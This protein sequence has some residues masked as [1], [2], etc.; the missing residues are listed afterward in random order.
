MGYLETGIMHDQELNRFTFNVNIDHKISERIKVGFT[1]FNTLIRSNRLGTNAFGRQPD[2]AHCINLIMMMDQ[3]IFKPAIQQGVDQNQINPLTSIGNDELIKAFQRRYQFQH[4]F[5]GEWKIIKDLKFK[6]TFGYGWSQTFN[7]NYTGPNTVFN[8]NATTAGSNLSQ[9]NSEGWQY[10]INNSLE[11][12]K[13]F[14]GRH[15]LQVQ[16]LQEVQ[17]NHFQ[18]QQFNGQGVPADYIQDYNWQ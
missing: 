2:L 12:N 9:S 17:K 7:S 4:N 1:S 13:T 8:T 11:Y 3:S 14:A 15:K 18:A 5:Y 16:A 6:T 10:T